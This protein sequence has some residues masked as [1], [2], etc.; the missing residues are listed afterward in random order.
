MTG[1]RSKS[2]FCPRHRAVF[3][4]PRTSSSSRK[5]PLPEITHLT[6]KSGTSLSPTCPPSNIPSSWLKSKR[7][8]TPITTQ[9]QPFLSN[10]IIM[11]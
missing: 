8:R 10:S 4:G 11:V 1:F 2:W 6:V 7:E 5:E 9:Q 3:A